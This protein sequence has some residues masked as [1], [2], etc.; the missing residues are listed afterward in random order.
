MH[1]MPNYLTAYARMGRYAE[2]EKLHV[3][4]CVEC[5]T[6]SYNCP[7]Q[8]QIV[9]YIRVAKGAIRAEQAAARARAA[10]SVPEFEQGV[11]S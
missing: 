2:A 9:Q 4:N 6:C 10:A 11:K 1:L 3:M 5:G 8:V 7:G